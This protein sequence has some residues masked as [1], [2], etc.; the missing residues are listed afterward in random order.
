[1][2]PS[3]ISLPSWSLC[4]LARYLAVPYF[5]LCCNV[6]GKCGP[7]AASCLSQNCREA[8]DQGAGWRH[9]GLW[10]VVCWAPQHVLSLSNKVPLI[11][12]PLVKTQI[13]GILSSLLTIHT[14]LSA[15][16]FPHVRIRRHYF[17][18]ELCLKTF[19]HA[20]VS[21]DVYHMSLD[22]SIAAFG[23]LQ[24]RLPLASPNSWV[25]SF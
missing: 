9:P 19:P 10:W 2:F 4:M 25:H 6:L 3:L 11:W 5:V 15:F 21:P 24:R 18:R 7:G 23:C 13:K 16:W 14:N 17:Q 1:M 20:Q 22:D 12:W 8:E